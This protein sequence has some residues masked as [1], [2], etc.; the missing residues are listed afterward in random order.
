MNRLRIGVDVGG[1]NT[2]AVVIAGRQVLTSVK[3]PTTTDVLTGIVDALNQVMR[4]VETS[5]V[6][7]LMIGTTH[8]TNAVV[9]AKDLARTGVVRLAGSATKAVPPMADWPPAIRA[10]VEGDV[11]YVSGGYEYDGREIGH[12]DLEELT[13]VGR[14]FRAAGIGDAAVTGVFSPVRADQE[15]EAA[16]A[17]EE[18]APGLLVSRS[19]E[20]GR[21]GL[22][23]RENATILNASLRP[24]ASRIVDAFEGAVASLGIDGATLYLSQNDG[25]LMG[26][27][28]TR[29]YP[30]ATFASG[31]TNSMR[32]AAFLSGE[33]DCAVID[34]GGTT[35]DVGILRHG[36]PREAPLAVEI[37]GIRT[38]FRM[39]DLVSIGV[40]GGSIVREGRDVTVGPDSVGHRLTSRAIVFGGETLT[41]TD[42]AVAAELATVGNPDRVAGLD[43]ALV[44]EALAVI[45]SQVAGAL[46]R[47]KTGPDPI[48]V[49][50]VGGGSIILGDDLTGASTILKPEHS[51]VANAIGAALAQVGGHA[52]RIVSYATGS[53]QEALQ[54]VTE[55]AQRRCID[56]GA[57]PDSVKVVD[58]DEVPL[59]YLPSNAVRVSAR[60]VGDLS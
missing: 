44:R 2:D 56:A 22:I 17:L 29:S 54:S 19:T 52:D 60:T 49:V 28:H 57:L 21:I 18:A 45:E 30:V 10:S 59:A 33:T 31:P 42:V 46:D 53:R 43:T 58:L 24:L 41:A 6:G 15:R 38:N 4:E 35:T 37:G 40:G 55:E 14:S 7:A 3:R 27:S 23:E 39:P 20:I 50:L 51:S 32:G 34:I 26:A 47:M 9:E 16:R 12:I 48:P 11:H 13:R 36:F 8:F 5:D 1:T 25:T